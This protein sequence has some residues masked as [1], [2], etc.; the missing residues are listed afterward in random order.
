MLVVCWRLSAPIHN[1]GNILAVI[2]FPTGAPSVE[3]IRFLISFF[4][5]DLQDYWPRLNTLRCSLKFNG[6]KIFFACDE[7]HLGR[8]ALYPAN[9]VNPV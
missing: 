5:Q 3:W 8:R 9:P 6:V 7:I 1:Y 2:F 4:G